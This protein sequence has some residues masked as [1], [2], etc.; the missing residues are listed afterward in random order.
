MAADRERIVAEIVDLVR[1]DVEYLIL[2]GKDPD[3]VA[4]LLTQT[5]GSMRALAQVLNKSKNPRALTLTSKEVE[6]CATVRA[7]LDEG[8]QWWWDQSILSGA[9]PLALARRVESAVAAA[10]VDPE[11][12][13]I[14]LGL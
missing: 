1:G 2:T 9:H 14:Q 7:T 4:M 10:I 5:L 8:A 6:E 12:D 3:A 13:P 11:D